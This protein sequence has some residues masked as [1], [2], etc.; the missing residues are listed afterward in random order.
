MEA[1]HSMS[2]DRL[3]HFFAPTPGERLLSRATS[4]KLELHRYDPDALSALARGLEDNA[5]DQPREPVV[6]L[7]YE[8][9]GELPLKGK[10]AAELIG[11]IICEFR[12]QRR[13][14]KGG[15]A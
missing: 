9:K 11:G 13:G 1:I 8:L 2:S 5:S 7:S 3:R 10:E 6:E 15:E 12:R 14:E 4:V